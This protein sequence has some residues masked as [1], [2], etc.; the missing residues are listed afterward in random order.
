MTALIFPESTPAE[1]I[2]ALPS[3][4]RRLVNEL[5]DANLSEDEAAQ[6]WLSR[7]GSDNTLGFGST[8]SAKRYLDA[9]KDEFRKLVCGGGGYDDIRQDFAVLWGKGKIT[10]ISTVAV[11]ISSVTSIAVGVVTPVV[12]LLFAAACKVGINAWCSTS[13]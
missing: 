7:S 4:E 10:L 2:A 1:W 11:A 13:N 3:S 6:F 8:G 9:V 5:L 12:A